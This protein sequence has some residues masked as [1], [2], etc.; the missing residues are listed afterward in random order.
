MAAEPEITRGPA[1]Y[2]I[3]APKSPTELDREIARLNGLQQLSLPRRIPAYL[4]L[5]GPGTLN[6]AVTLGAG[7]LTSAMLSGAQF[8]YR[9]LWMSWLAMGLGLFMLFGIARITSQGGFRLVPERNKRYGWMIAKA[10]SCLVGVVLV[11]VAFNFGQVALGTH[12]IESVAETAGLHFPQ[13]LNWPFYGPVSYTHLT[14]PTS[15]LV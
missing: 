15:D 12:L 9:T 11:A 7:T 8:G 4:K 2:P 13:H 3:A 6:A 5:A 1:E 14:L 10:M